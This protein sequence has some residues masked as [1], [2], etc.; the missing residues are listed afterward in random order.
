PSSSPTVPL[1]LNPKGHLRPIEP[2]IQKAEA[3]GSHSKPAWSTS[4]SRTARTTQRNPVL[5]NSNKMSGCGDT[6]VMKVL[7]LYRLADSW[8]S[9]ASSIGPCDKYFQK[10]SGHT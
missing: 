9:L 6:L 5:K 3:D 1:T 2:S 10:H 8:D 4:S 7:R